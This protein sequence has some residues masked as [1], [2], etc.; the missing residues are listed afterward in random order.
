MVERM[1]H[2]EK[3]ACAAVAPLIN[4]RLDTVAATAMAAAN[5]RLRVVTTLWRLKDSM[6]AK[7][8]PCAVEELIVH[9]RN[10][11]SRSL[12]TRISKADA[13]TIVETFL[14]WYVFPNCLPCQGSGHLPHESNA[15]T[16]QDA[17]C[18]H[19]G[20]TGITSLRSAMRDPF[21]TGRKV[22]SDA[23]MWLHDTVMEREYELSRKARRRVQVQT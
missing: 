19:C 15:Q 11:F 21:F 23:L 6:D 12:D 4:N 5:P 20:G 7:E 13:R 3:Y 22:F 9:L 10:K 14:K 1:K 16:R 17:P 8:W 18:P 2:E